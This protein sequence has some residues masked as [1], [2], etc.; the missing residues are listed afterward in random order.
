MIYI[1][2]PKKLRSNNPREITTWVG[3]S[4]MQL[5]VDRIDITV[6]ND[7]QTY[8]LIDSETPI[9][10]YR[11]AT[12]GMIITGYITADSNLVGSGSFEKVKNLIFAAREWYVE[13]NANQLTDGNIYDCGYSRIRWDNKSWN[14]LIRKIVITDHADDSGSTDKIFD[15]IIDL[16]LAH[17]ESD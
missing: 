4:W 10:Q 14:M 1:C 11:A 16:V 3:T 5:D 7:V 12:M 8:K 15:Y 6:N 17:N 2:A 13:L 9:A